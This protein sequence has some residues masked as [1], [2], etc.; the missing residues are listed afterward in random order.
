MK[1]IASL[2]LTPALEAD[3]IDTMR[4]IPDF[5]INQ[6]TGRDSLITITSSRPERTH[7]RGTLPWAT[8]I[9]AKIALY[10]LDTLHRFRLAHILLPNLPTNR[11]I[12]T[13]KTKPIRSRPR[14]LLRRKRV[15]FWSLWKPT[16]PSSQDRVSSEEWKY[17]LR[18]N[19]PKAL[20]T[21]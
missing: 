2:N 8:S 16:D 3:T 12:L 20:L 10:R 17:L 4:K 21:D 15:R 5:M 6:G 9:R 13:L 14:T 7:C 11:S 19:L 1:K 18:A